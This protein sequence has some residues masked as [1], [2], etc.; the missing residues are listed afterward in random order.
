L[1]ATVALLAPAAT[2]AQPEVF[3]DLQVAQ[4]GPA[5]TRPAWSELAVVTEVKTW[6]FENYTRVVVYFDR[7]VRWEERTLAADAKADRPA[8]IY[9]DLMDTRL[10]PSVPAELPIDDGLLQRARIAQF[11]KQRARLVLDLKSLAAWQVVPFGDP[12]RLVIDVRGTQGGAPPVAAAPV[13]KGP[14]GIEDI[15]G[16][17]PAPVIKAPPATKAPTPSIQKPPQPPTIVIDA[18]HGGKDPGAIGLKGIREKD[19]VLKVARD[20]GGR[21]QR[22]GYRV[23]YTR[24]DDRFLKLEERTIVANRENADLFVS[25]HA[26][27]APN[28]KAFGIETYRLARATDKDSAAVAA[29]ENSTTG[30]SDGDLL[31]DLLTAL[32]L[33]NKANESTPLAQYVQKSIVD[34]LSPHWKPFRS[35]GVKGAPFYVLVGTEMPAILIEIGFVTNPVEAKRLRDSRYLGQLAEG[36]TSGIQQFLRT[37]NRTP[38]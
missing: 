24:A 4:A 14:S 22:A 20:V 10:A 32:K 35:I 11:D 5:N 21:L 30:S 38:I 16:G 1:L 25:I 19:V 17:K 37:V 9:L 31:D 8:R 33:T 26:N 12:F 15:L 3:V 27:S 13:A 2:L 23:I 7:K 6:T 28:P 34:T 29:R 36:I 18:G